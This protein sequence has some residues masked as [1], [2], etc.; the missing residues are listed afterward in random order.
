[1]TTA[2]TVDF[3]CSYGARSFS[4]W[5]YDVADNFVQVWDSGDETE[6]LMAVNGEWLNG[7]TNKRNDDKGAEPEG[8]ITGRFL[9]KTLAFIAL[10]RSGGCSSTM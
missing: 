9:G 6:Q 5:K 7:Y 4:I 1:M 10:E 8:V 2:T 3:I